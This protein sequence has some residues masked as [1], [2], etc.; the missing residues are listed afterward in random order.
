MK[1]FVLVMLAVV[2]GCGVL[3]DSLAALSGDRIAQLAVL[4]GAGSLFV[5]LIKKIEVKNKNI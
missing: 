1:V 3:V 5:M 2:V 4:F